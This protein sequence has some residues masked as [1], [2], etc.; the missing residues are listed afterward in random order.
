MHDIIGLLNVLL[1]SKI[2]FGQIYINRSIYNKYYDLFS[3]Y[4]KTFLM[5][6][7]DYN[8]NSVFIDLRN[9]DKKIFTEMMDKTIKIL[10]FM[11]W[12]VNEELDKIGLLRCA[13]KM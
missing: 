1:I 13:L 12:E 5:I 7:G 3:K 2:D 11:G 10:S 6:N 4:D 8:V 9:I